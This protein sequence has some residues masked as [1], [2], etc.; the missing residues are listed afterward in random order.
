M[1]GDLNMSANKSFLTAI[2]IFL[3]IPGLIIGYCLGYQNQLTPCFEAKF[4]WKIGED[5]AIHN[6]FLGGSIMLGMTIGAVMGGVLMKIGRRKSMFICIVVGTIGNLCT[7]D[8]HSF[9]LLIL[10]RFLFGV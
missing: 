6:A 5:Q 9:Y 8:I 3:N 7:L 10:G 4:G 2:I 1:N